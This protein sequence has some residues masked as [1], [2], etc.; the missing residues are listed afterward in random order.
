MHFI[1]FVFFMQLEELQLYGNDFS[2]GL[3]AAV[4]RLTR[5]KELSLLM[6]KLRDIPDWVGDL[7]AVCSFCDYLKFVIVGVS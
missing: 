6:C 5:L 4:G 7:T 3:N 1:S 2:N